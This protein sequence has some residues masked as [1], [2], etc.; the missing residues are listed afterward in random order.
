MQIRGKVCVHLVQTVSRVRAEL[1]LVTFWATAVFT[2]RPCCMFTRVFAES[3]HQNAAGAA[4]A[5][6]PRWNALLTVTIN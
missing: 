4:T 5:V 2:G 3:Q 6:L 1:H